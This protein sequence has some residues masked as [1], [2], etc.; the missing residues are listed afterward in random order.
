MQG[1]IF[2]N[3]W[4]KCCRDPWECHNAAD[5]NVTARKFKKEI[6]FGFFFLNELSEMT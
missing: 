3:G 5:T 2:L 4:E 1:D 6:F